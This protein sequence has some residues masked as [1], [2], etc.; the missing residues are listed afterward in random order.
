MIHFEPLRED[1][2]SLLMEWFNRAHVQAFYS[3]HNWTLEEVQ[4]KYLPYVQNEKPVHCYIAYLDGKP[5]AFIQDYPLKDFGWPGHDFTPDVI[6]K[7]GGIDLFIGEASMLNRGFGSQLLEVFL[8]EHV[9]PRYDFCVVDPEARN[10]ASQ[11]FFERCGFR[12]HKTIH[13]RD[14]LERDGFEREVSLVLMTRK[15]T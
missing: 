10:I 5:F 11:R 3:L 2:F 7:S 9:W 13:T 6:Q 4:L 12:T 8:Q 15:R 1:H 14:T